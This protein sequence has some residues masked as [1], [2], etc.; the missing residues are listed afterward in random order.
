ME[1]AAGKGKGKGRAEAAAPVSEG[2]GDGSGD[3]DRVEEEDVIA[4]WRSRSPPTATGADP[5]LTRT[6]SEAEADGK[7]GKKS[8][9]GLWRRVTGSSSS[10]DSPPIEKLG[11]VFEIGPASQPTDDAHTDSAPLRSSQGATPVSSSSSKL[12]KQHSVQHIRHD[13]G[14]QPREREGAALLALVNNTIP[15][16]DSQR[17][18]NGSSST[19]SSSTFASASTVKVSAVDAETYKKNAELN[20]RLQ[21]V[22]GVPGTPGFARPAGWAQD[23]GLTS[24]KEA[25]EERGAE[26]R[27]RTGGKPREDQ[28]KLEQIGVAAEEEWLEDYNPYS[29]RSDEPMD[30]DDD[31]DSDIDPQG[32][33]STFKP[34]HQHY[35]RDPRLVQTCVPK[36]E[37]FQS[38]N[39]ARARNLD[40]LFRTALSRMDNTAYPSGDNKAV[41]RSEWRESETTLGQ[42]HGDGV[43]LA[44]FSNTKQYNMRVENPDDGED[45]EDED[46]DDGSIVDHYAFTS[47]SLPERAASAIPT[48]VGPKAFGTRNSFPS[49]LAPATAI[50]PPPVIARQRTN[51][52]VIRSLHRGKATNVKVKH[53]G[54]PPMR[55]VPQLPNA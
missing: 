9:R 2:S 11:E 37:V 4:L 14:R 39:R 32:H 51:T 25:K 31:D 26:V 50:A 27:M 38:D 12:R 34:Q 42:N 18:P 47:H 53:P 24:K 28:E 54:P 52:P 1:K 7:E 29:S 49:S 36:D 30:D 20:L 5:P 55:P 48:Q 45:A 17:G 40:I 19:F 13:D 15:S 10:P 16:L 3:G 46:E 41:Y 23:S 6:K 43:V 35:Q 21:S 8:F 22:R 44:S 33:P